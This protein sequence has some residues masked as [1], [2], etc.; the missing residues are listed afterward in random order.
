MSETTS[1]LE[2]FQHM[3][4]RENPIEV[5]EIEIH[6]KRPGP[7]N[8]IMFRSSR[9]TGPKRRRPRDEA[10]G[11]GEHRELEGGQVGVHWRHL[12]VRDQDQQ[13]V[14]RSQIPQ[15]SVWNVEEPLLDR[16]LLLVLVST[17]ACLEC[18]EPLDGSV[19]NVEL[20]W[21]T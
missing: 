10:E 21:G 1:S 8:S 3:Q 17:R 12:Q 13:G 14:A 9:L 18:A 19:W 15:S 20:F 2:K 5:S 6:L 11:P 16:D 7:V 4:G